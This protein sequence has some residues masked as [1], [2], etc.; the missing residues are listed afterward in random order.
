[1]SKRRPSLSGSQFDPVDHDHTSQGLLA[2]IINKLLFRN[3][4][5]SVLRRMIRGGHGV[6]GR[7]T[8]N[9]LLEGRAKG[10]KG[11]AGER[12]R[13]QSAGQ[14][15]GGQAADAAPSLFSGY[16]A[17]MAGEMGHGDGADKSSEKSRSESCR[18]G[19]S[20]SPS[21]SKKQQPDD[22]RLSLVSLVDDAIVP[23]ELTAEE[24]ELLLED[25]PEDRLLE[26]LAERRSEYT[27]HLRRL[28][29]ARKQL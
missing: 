26:V 24:F 25:T 10:R 13:R 6:V 12:G 29:N 17:F 21:S 14:A 28:E 19:E 3:G 23:L 5:S 8:A 4:S 9:L 20:S 2:R 18:K 16:S 7:D 1:M 11:T 22:R 15:V 27:M